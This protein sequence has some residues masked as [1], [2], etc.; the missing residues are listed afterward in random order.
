MKGTKYKKK[1]YITEEKYWTVHGRTDRKHPLCF[2]RAPGKLTTVVVIVIMINI[3]RI[4]VTMINVIVITIISIMINQIIINILV[5]NI[6]NTNKKTKLSKRDICH[7]FYLATPDT[8]HGV[9]QLSLSCWSD[10]SEPSRP[11]S[12]TEDGWGGLGGENRKQSQTATDTL[13]SPQS[14]F[15]WGLPLDVGFYPEVWFNWS[16]LIFQEG[17]TFYSLGLKPPSS[18]DSVRRF[19]K[20]LIIWFPLQLQAY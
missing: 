10:L 7:H 14:I 3:T 2:S 6:T 9:A 20:R 11:R 4:N 1:L 18:M 13:S 15:N 17:W 8:R 5:I 16:H 19:S 12:S